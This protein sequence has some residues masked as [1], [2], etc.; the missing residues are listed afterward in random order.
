MGLTYS[1]VV[2]ASLDEVFSWHAR[3]GAITRLAPPWQPVR[4]I[5]E[6]SGSSGAGSL[7]DG[8][9]VLG[10]PGGLRWVAAHQPDGY[11][12]PYAFA[13]SLE[14][15][16]LSAVL[17]WRHTHEFSPAGEA[18]TLVTDVVDT[19]LPAR[20]LRS[21]FLYRHRQLAGDLAALARARTICP[22]TL[23]TAV[24]G[25]GGL[26]GTALTALLTTSGHQVIRLVRRL[27]RHAGERYWRPEDPGPDLLDGVDAVIH[28]AGASIGGRFTP[29]RKNEIRASR[30]LPTRRLAELA[31][32]TATTTGATTTGATTT[33][34]TT[35]GEPGLRAFVAA[36]AIGI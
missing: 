22:D 31:A 27:P 36:S 5:R 11:D 20:A 18:A 16:P 8:R 14:S 6:A 29:E 25:S 34:A 19:P 35:T 2:D 7:R 23:T 9:A 4:V 32:A 10:L 1:S 24:T 15:L 21:M 28:L 3:P 30:I 13:D 12:P 33:G 17:P 26:I